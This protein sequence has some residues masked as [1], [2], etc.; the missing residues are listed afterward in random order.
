MYV[1]I[2][3]NLFPTDRLENIWR[4]FQNVL[5]NATLITKQKLTLKT[6][7]VKYGDLGCVEVH[8]IRVRL[9]CHRRKQQTVDDKFTRCYASDGS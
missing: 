5:P 2:S 9:Y 4:Q 8:N 3:N 6:I 7:N 1:D